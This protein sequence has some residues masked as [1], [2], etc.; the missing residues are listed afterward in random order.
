MDAQPTK[1]PDNKHGDGEADQRG[2]GNPRRRA[3]PVSIPRMGS[4]VTIKSHNGRPSQT[5]IVVG[6]DQQYFPNPRSL[7]VHHLDS[8]RILLIEVTELTT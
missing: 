1:Q 3:V 6:P 2:A 7:F 8:D 5:G 4:R